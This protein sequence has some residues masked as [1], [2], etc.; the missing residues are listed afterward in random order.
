MESKFLAELIWTNA[1]YGSFQRS[2]IYSENIS[3][4]EALEFRKL[5]RRFLKEKIF[6]SFSGKKVSEQELLKLIRQLKIESENKPYIV[7]F[8]FG[9][10]QKFI[11]LYLKGMW[12]TGLLLNP[13]PHAPIN[14]QIINRFGRKNINF[15]YDGKTLA[16][17]RIDEPQYMLL[18]DLIKK[19]VTKEGKYSTIAEWELNEYFKNIPG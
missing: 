12:V 5:V 6:D 17:T 16:W 1:K 15:K 14:S 13:P 11:N 10:A 3:K 18:I 9:N 2:D 4:A 8:T 19:K 7:N